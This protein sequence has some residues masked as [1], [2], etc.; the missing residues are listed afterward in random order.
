MQVARGKTGEAPSPPRPSLAHPLLH[1][2]CQPQPH[3]CPAADCQHGLRYR[4]GV[5]LQLMGRLVQWLSAD[6]FI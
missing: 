2:H 3:A 5:C 6:I 1:V 4:Q